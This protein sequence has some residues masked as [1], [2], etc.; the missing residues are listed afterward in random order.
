M[1]FHALKLVGAFLWR[2]G[3]LLDR[4]TRLAPT[5]N[6]KF[7][8][9]LVGIGSLLAGGAGK[10]PVA[11]IVAKFFAENDLRV[12]LLCYPTGDENLWKPPTSNITVVTGRDRW[13]LCKQ[14]DGQFDVLV[15]DDGFEDHRLTY[16][17]W[18][19]LDWGE[20]PRG[21]GD[22]IPCGL[23]RS[24]AR[25]HLGVRCVLR[26]AMATD[27]DG[28]HADLLFTTTMPCNAKGLA[29][30]AAVVAMAGVARPER[31]FRGL[32]MAGV[33]VCEFVARPDHDPHFGTLLRSRLRKNQRVAIT[34]KD[35]ARLSPE[36]LANDNLFVAD[37]D[38]QGDCLPWADLTAL[39][40]IGTF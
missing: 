29:P 26:C 13:A 39:A 32:E 31:F 27:S 1:P 19:R 22:L 24:F 40:R 12:G 16:G 15:S 38:V 28:G 33:M 14:Y 9:P 4:S 34:A 2:A 37:L 8:T 11:R 30:D 3:Y 5:R 23:Y 36:D 35:A 17:Y 10:T 7:K 20:L 6:I 25:D 21:I 18:I